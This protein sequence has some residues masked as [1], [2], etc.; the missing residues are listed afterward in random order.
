MRLGKAADHG[1]S[2]LKVD[3]TAALRAA[4]KAPRFRTGSRR[5]ERSRKR[6]CPTRT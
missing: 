6:S 3:V 5:S 1:G 2:D 4:A